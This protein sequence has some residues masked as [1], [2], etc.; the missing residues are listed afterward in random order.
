MKKEAT[1]YIVR[2]DGELEEKHRYRE[3]VVSLR[4]TEVA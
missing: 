2:R 1:Q 4:K 3:T